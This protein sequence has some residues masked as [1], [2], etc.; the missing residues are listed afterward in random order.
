MA[1][2]LADSTVTLA[3]AIVVAFVIAR[4]IGPS[5]FGLGS[6]AYLIGSFAEA[7]VAVPL[8]ESLIQR[9]TFSNAAADT[10][11]VLMAMLGLGVFVI[12]VISA[13]LFAALLDA[14]SLTMLIAAQGITLL[15]LALRG[16]PEALL[17]R[18]LRF[19]AL[20]IRNICAKLAMVPAAL[21][22]ALNGAGAWAIVGANIAFAITSTIMV[23]LVA[24]RWPRPRFDRE[25][26]KS[27][28]RFGFF[29]MLD[30]AL[31]SATPRLF[32]FLFGH[33]QGI[34]AL[35]QLNLGFRIND[36]VSALIASVTARVALPVF[37][38]SARRSPQEF[39]AAFAMGTRLTMLIAL[40]AFVGLALVSEEI[41]AM[42]LGPEWPQS[43][44]ALRAV[45]LYS[46]VNFARVL[47]QPAIKAAGKPAALIWLHVIGL[48]YIAGAMVM[49]RNRDFVDLLMVWVGFGPVYFLT[50]AL[51][52]KKVIGMGV[53]E[54]VRPL[55]PAT[56]IGAV[57]A[58]AVFAAD[59]ALGEVAP[60]AGLAIKIAIAAPVFLGLAAVLEWPQLRRAMTLALPSGQDRGEDTGDGQIVPKPQAAAR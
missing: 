25:E 13:P 5:E 19:R 8:A 26:A 1:W 48:A 32:A 40:P 14:P 54:Q 58:T 18:K 23:L 42:F 7:F 21:V 35:G 12:M 6:T 46:I 60:L 36:T 9:R 37:S 59:K 44:D 28:F 16:T 43:V 57:M 11:F 31:W 4:I 38:R 24:P 17:A 52:L 27:L 45:F 53:L 39:V 33:F 2:V 47:A 30:G 20:S 3:S 41:V 15:F 56:L 34:R 50:S 55:V 22:L 10:G 49:M 51:L 29:A